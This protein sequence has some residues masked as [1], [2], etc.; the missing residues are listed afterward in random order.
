LVV[1]SGPQVWVFTVHNFLP[2]GLSPKSEA[3]LRVLKRRKIAKLRQSVNAKKK[4]VNAKKQLRQSVNA[5][6]RQSVNAK[7]QLRQSVNAKK[8]QLRQS[9]NAKRKAN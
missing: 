3:K 2:V 6:L 5:K 7:K 8:Q 9:V 4:S 1:T